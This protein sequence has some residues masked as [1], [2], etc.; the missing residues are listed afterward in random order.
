MENWWERVGTL[1]E[2]GMCF[3]LWVL[4]YNWNFER[5]ISPNSQILSRKHNQPIKN[6]KNFY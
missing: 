5:F 2:D 6:I 1:T 3:G 4:S